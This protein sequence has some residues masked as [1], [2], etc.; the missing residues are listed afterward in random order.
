MLIASFFSWWYGSGLKK[1]FELLGSKLD[2]TRDFFSIGLLIK[3]LF[4]PFRMID[5]NVVKN[6]S[7]DQKIRS[8]VDKL[9]SSF[10]GALIRLTVVI[11]GAFGL[12]FQA[13]FGLI[14]IGF[15][16]LMP[17]MPVVFLILFALGWVPKWPW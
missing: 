16:I 15:W 10:I 3:T 11:V 12:A 17:I 13:V 5:A 14:A 8:M 9:I 4:S 7:L 6:G 1:R 2:L